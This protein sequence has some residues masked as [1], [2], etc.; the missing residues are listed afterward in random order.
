[1]SDPRIAGPLSALAVTI[2]DEVAKHKTQPPAVQ[3][4][5]RA[6][7]GAFLLGVCGYLLATLGPYAARIPDGYKLGWA[8]AAAWGAILLVVGWQN[9]RGTPRNRLGAL[10]AIAVPAGGFF[11]V[12]H[13]AP[14]LLENFYVRAFSAGVITANAVRFVIDISGPGGNALQMVNENIAEN[15]FTWE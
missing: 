2:S 11:L 15:E 14:G 4:E 12:A 5:N 1:M 13:Y 6:F 3:N 7:G 9:A 10:W 8:A